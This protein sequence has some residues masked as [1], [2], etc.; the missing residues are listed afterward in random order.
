MIDNFLYKKT[1][2]KFVKIQKKIEIFYG[3]FFHFL[4]KNFV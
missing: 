4:I 1:K 3:R 2:F